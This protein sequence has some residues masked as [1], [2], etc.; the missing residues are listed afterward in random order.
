MGY[1][2]KEER[3]S[4][5][6]GSG[7]E[8]ELCPHCNGTRSRDNESCG[9]CSGTGRIQVSCGRCGGS[10][11]VEIDVWQSDSDSSSSSYDSSSSSSSSSY[12]PSRSGSPPKF[13]Y[14][15]DVKDF[16][17]IMHHAYDLIDTGNF[18]AAI[19]VA[20]RLANSFTWEEQ[21][22]RLANSIRGNAESR[23]AD[24]K[25]NASRGS[26]SS[27][28]FSAVSIPANASA[29]ELSKLAIEAYTA[30]DFIKAIALWQKAEEKGCTNIDKACYSWTLVEVGNTA[31][32]DQNYVAAAELYRKA[33]DMGNKNGQNNI[34][35][36]YFNGH[37]V[38]QDHAKAA[39]WY[40]KAAAQ[41]H[42]GAQKKLTEM[43]VKWES[44]GSS[45][46]SNPLQE[47]DQLFNAGNYDKAILKY[48]QSIRKG[49][50]KALALMKR[51]ACYVKK[52]DKEQAIDNY[53]D[54]INSGL[55][56]SDLAT[57]KAELAKLKGG[58]SS[59]SAND[60]APSPMP[61]GLSPKLQ[62]LHK[63]AE[64]GDANAQ[65]EF[66]EAYFHNEIPNGTRKEAMYWC[67]KAAE[68]GHADAQCNLGC[69]YQG[70]DK[71][72]AIYWFEKAAAQGDE[73]SKECLAELEAEEE[74]E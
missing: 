14:A 25:A 5:C 61:S 36:S 60:E 66:A 63:A 18:D 4:R 70:T 39:E 43:G 50:N 35:N 62:A 20:Q 3:C 26:S 2:K 17:K 46:A 11:Y 41:G 58:S 42:E 74:E 15:G 10:G 9:Y 1:V 59:A 57:A 56:G 6:Y 44:G 23:K 65:W 32:N 19:D 72:K 7:K 8:E 24:A 16:E 13:N 71:A 22:V 45:S 29:N 68:N 28:M 31:F 54:A 48:S 69:H 21:L 64:N 12:T 37:G 27:E 40:K 51:A 47:A 67:T 49:E 30:K 33:A 52:G 55:T 34:G 73:Y 53:T 38:T